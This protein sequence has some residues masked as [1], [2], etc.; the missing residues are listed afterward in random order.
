[1]DYLSVE[2]GRKRPGMKLVLTKGYLAPWSESAKAVFRLRD[3][4]Y[5]AVEQKAGEANDA[6][7]DWTGMRNAPIAIYGEEPPRANYL[8]I[9]MLAERLGTHHSLIPTEAIERLLCLGACADIAGDGGFGWN[10]R[11][12]MFAAIYGEPSGANTYPPLVAQ[13]LSD[14]SFNRD[15][16][17]RAKGRAIE[18]MQG[19]DELL[20]QSGQGYLVG[21]EVTAADIYWAI[22]SNMVVPLPHDVNPMPDAQRVMYDCKDEEILDAFSPTLREHRDRIYKEH[23]GFPVVF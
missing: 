20:A 12:L 21:E 19:L 2:E 13:I 5:R 10:M 4:Y 8:E 23:L 22:F 14:Y 17:Q 15:T 3:V 1:M 18:I 16:L 9:L 7:V 11:L 6:L